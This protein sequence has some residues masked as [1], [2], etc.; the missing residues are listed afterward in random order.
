MSIKIHNIDVSEPSE[1]E[2]W[3]SSADKFDPFPFD[4]IW[5]IGIEHY[6]IMIIVSKTSH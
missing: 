4:P 6:D 3:T 1:Y 2:L 5:S